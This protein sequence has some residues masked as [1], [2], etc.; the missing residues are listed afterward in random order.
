M[1]DQ[2]TDTDSGNSVDY[3]FW[4]RMPGWTIAEA[5]ALLVGLDPD[6]VS[7]ETGKDALRETKHRQYYQL[8]R[9]LKRARKM[10]DLDDPMRPRDFLEWAV[11]NKLNVS[12]DLQ[13][14]VHIGKKL[15]NWRQ[16]YFSMKRKRDALVDKS[17]DV[18]TPKERTSLL[19]IILAMV[20][21][22]LKHQAG[23][24]H[25]VSAIRKAVEKAELKLSDD[26]IRKYLS[27]AEEK[28]EVQ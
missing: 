22:I 24:P 7:S 1:T 21:Q 14:G 12:H 9:R 23:N 17:K 6:S 11:S 13:Q 18:V 8:R 15:Q 26:A 4:G 28:L 5:A 19:T 16:K 3:E 2:A 25:T 10:D 20:R 27:E